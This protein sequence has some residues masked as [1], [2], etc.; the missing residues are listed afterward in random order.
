MDNLPIAFDIFYKNEILLT[1]GISEE[2]Y[3]ALKDEVLSRFRDLEAGPHKMGGFQLKARRYKE[4]TEDEGFNAGPQIAWEVETVKIL[5]QRVQYNHQDEM[6]G[7]L[8]GALRAY[9]QEIYGE[10][11]RGSKEELAHALMAALGQD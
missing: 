9:R 3:S 10:D 6:L 5:S 8:K 4:T 7:P 2:H 1:Y 11:R